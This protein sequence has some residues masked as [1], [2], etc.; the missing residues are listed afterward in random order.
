[1]KKTDVLII[2]GSAA[3]LAVA[4]AGKSHYPNKSFLL[5]RIEEQVMIR[6]LCRQIA[7]EKIKPVRNQSKTGKEFHDSPKL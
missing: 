5:I 4:T 1:M 2:G 6:D 3:G 7:E